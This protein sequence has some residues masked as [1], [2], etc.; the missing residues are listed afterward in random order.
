MAPTTMFIEK[1]NDQDVWVKGN[2]KTTEQLFLTLANLN[3]KLKTAGSDTV[4]SM[5]A[6]EFDKSKE[7]ILTVDS[8]KIAL[9]PI[10][11]RERILIDR[12][13]ARKEHVEE[14]DAGYVAYVDNYNL[15]VTDEKNAHQVTTDG[16]ND[17]VYASSVHREEFGITKGTFWS[18]SRTRL[19]FYWTT[20]PATVNLIKYPFVGDKSHHVTVGVSC[21]AEIIYHH[22]SRFVYQNIMHT[23]HHCDQFPASLFQI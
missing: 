9:D 5:P 7:W 11:N 23:R 17:I 15:F 14:S 16:S 8:N 22:R 13:I 19:A 1:I 3:Q 10:T 12:T 6:I 4:T 21:V 2:L 20:T 18:T